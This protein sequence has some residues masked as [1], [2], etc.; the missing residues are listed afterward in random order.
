MGPK[1]AASGPNDR[2]VRHGHRRKRPKAATIPICRLLMPEK[3]SARH[4]VF[5]AWAKESWKLTLRVSE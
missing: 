2:R 3:T 5:H 1:E 4:R